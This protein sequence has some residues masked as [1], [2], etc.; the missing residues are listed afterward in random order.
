MLESNTH[1]T[2]S[3]SPEF[4]E[5]LKDHVRKGQSYESY[6]KSELSIYDSQNETR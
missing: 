6:L 1:T 5:E 3:V 2:I 4:L